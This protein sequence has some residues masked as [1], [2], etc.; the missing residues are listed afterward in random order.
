ML[1]KSS[2]EYWVGEAFWKEIS[3]MK[4]QRTCSLILNMDKNRDF[5]HI[6]TSKGQEET[7]FDF[8]HFSTTWNFCCQS[9]KKLYQHYFLSDST[10]IFSLSKKKSLFPTE[11]KLQSKLI[12]QSISKLKR[13][14][15]VK[16]NNNST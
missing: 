4:G 8:L 13:C 5:W 16:Q 7:S 1:V 11:K 2:Q 6:D 14:S 3:V 10:N 15:T 12:K 9:Q